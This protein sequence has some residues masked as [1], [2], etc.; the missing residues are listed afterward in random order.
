MAATL[1]QLTA[2]RYLW[3]KT[4]PRSPHHVEPGAFGEL[5]ANEAS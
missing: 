5:Y 4:H 1:V 2:G 3:P